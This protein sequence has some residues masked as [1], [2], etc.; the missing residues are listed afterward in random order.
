[1]SYHLQPVSHTNQQSAAFFV[2]HKING[3]LVTKNLPSYITFLLL[4]LF[5]LAIWFIHLLPLY[6]VAISKIYC[7]LISGIQFDDYFNF[8]PFNSLVLLFLLFPA[9]HSNKVQLMQL[10]TLSLNNY[11]LLCL[12]MYFECVCAFLCMS[13]DD[14]KKWEKKGINLF[15]VDYI[16]SCEQWLDYM[17]SCRYVVSK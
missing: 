11:C 2:S 10:S 3:F 7:L 1:M 17:D 15:A 13:C 16:R 4:H 8:F 9:N 6:I 5:T 12:N 14:D